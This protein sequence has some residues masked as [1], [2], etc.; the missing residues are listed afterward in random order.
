MTMN[1]KANLVRRLTGL[2]RSKTEYL[3]VHIGEAEANKLQVLGLVFCHAANL[4]TE[5]G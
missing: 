1:C 3:G 4:E 5:R 2:A